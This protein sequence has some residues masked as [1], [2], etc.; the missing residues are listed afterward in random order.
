MVSSGSSPHLSFGIVVVD[1][2]DRTW[3]DVDDVGRCRC[4]NVGDVSVR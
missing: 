2:D 1:V 3:F 4:R